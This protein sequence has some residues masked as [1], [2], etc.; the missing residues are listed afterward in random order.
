MKNV[1]LGLVFFFSFSGCAAIANFSNYSTVPQTV[2]G[3]PLTRFAIEN[4]GTAKYRTPEELY[5]VTFQGRNYSTGLVGNN[6]L[7]T[8]WGEVPNSCQELIKIKSELAPYRKAEAI[9]ILVSDCETGIERERKAAGEWLE[10]KKQE[11]VEHVSNFR[12]ELEAEFKEAEIEREKQLLADKRRQE[13]RE[14]EKRKEKEEFLKQLYATKIFNLL[15]ENNVDAKK[16]LAI[17]LRDRM[18]SSLEGT[19]MC[20]E[21]AYSPSDVDINYSGD[22]LVITFYDVVNN[23]GKSDAEFVFIDRSSYWLSTE[24]FM[25]GMRFDDSASKYTVFV[26]GLE[27]GDCLD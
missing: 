21:K 26:S 10:K 2:A 5:Y 1:I 13:Q 17:S 14:L 6:Y 25:H 8:R 24:M 3:V 23:R 27:L 12:R 9:E 11:D 19:L 15:K 16:A 20:F 4:E 7:E 18:P 22:K